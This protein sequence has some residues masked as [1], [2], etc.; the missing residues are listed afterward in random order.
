MNESR[1]ELIRQVCFNCGSFDIVLLR[2][3]GN[4]SV[5]KCNQCHRVWVSID[6]RGVQ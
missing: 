5:Y 6:R 1:S 2:T 3:T 4:K